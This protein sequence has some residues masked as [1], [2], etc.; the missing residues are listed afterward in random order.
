MKE[1]K[2]IVT[3]KLPRAAVNREILVESD[4]EFANRKDKDS[5]FEEDDTQLV[6]SEAEEGAAQRTHRFYLLSSA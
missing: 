3:V 5:E 6:E 4:D 1:S 2:K